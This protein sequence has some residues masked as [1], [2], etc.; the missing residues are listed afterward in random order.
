MGALRDYYLYIYYLLVELLKFGFI[1]VIFDDVFVR[2]FIIICVSFFNKVAPFLQCSA[3]I[4][5]MFP[6]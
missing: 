1:F 4:L 5:L 2:L 6:T 3:L